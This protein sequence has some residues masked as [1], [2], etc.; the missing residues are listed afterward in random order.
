MPYSAVTQPWPLPRRKG[1][2]LS[3]MVAV[4][5]TLVLPHSINTEPSACGR[6]PGVKVIGR[7]ASAAREVRRV[8]VIVFFLYH[9]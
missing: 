2:T 5:I 6:K 3:S 4:Q 7:R 8:A 9:G 1:G